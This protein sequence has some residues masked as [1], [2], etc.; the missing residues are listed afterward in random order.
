MKQRGNNPQCKKFKNYGAIGRTVCDRWL[1]SFD[2]FFEDM[3]E[4]PEGMTL[5]RIDNTKGYYKENCRW[6]TCKEQQN[7]RRDNVWY[8]YG[9]ER[10][11]ITQWAE[12][13]H[14]NMGT[15]W[16]RLRKYNWSIER[17]LNTPIKKCGPKS[18]NA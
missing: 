7:N 16:G 12:S 10:K 6:A 13:L 15:L 4:R 2:N 9:G 18:S 8:E 11:T 1:E 3:G 17:A 5:E 14:M